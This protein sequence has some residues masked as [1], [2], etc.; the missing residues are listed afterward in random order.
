[1]FDK[2]L[3]ALRSRPRQ[4]E[5]KDEWLFVTV[6]TM[7]A[8]IDNSKRD[9]ITEVLKAADC[10]TTAELQRMYDTIQGKYGRE[11]FTYRHAPAYYY[12]SSLIAG[13]PDMELNEAD[14]ENISKFYK[15]AEYLLYKV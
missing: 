13:Y 11:G 4:L 3:T 14:R 9:D 1:M 12:L 6:N 7:K 10:R 5:A 15:E 2:I 8:I